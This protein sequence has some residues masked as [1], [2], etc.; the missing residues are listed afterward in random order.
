MGAAKCQYPWS[1]DTATV[2]KELGVDPAQGV[3][4]DLEARR[5]RYGFNELEKQPGTSVWQLIL[6][7]FNDTLVK[8]S[9]KGRMPGRVD[10]LGPP[11]PHH[12]HINP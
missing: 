7:Q 9:V 12:A 10:Q 4:D 8:A 11:A 3:C 2:L 1:K 6:E 5:A